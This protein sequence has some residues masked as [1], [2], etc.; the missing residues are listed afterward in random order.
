MPSEYPVSKQVRLL[1]TSMPAEPFAGMAWS[2]GLCAA[3]LDPTLWHESLHTYARATHL[4]VALSDTRGQL[5]GECLNPQPTWHCLQA[6]AA[7]GV[8]C[9]V[10][11]HVISTINTNSAHTPWWPGRGGAV[12]RKRADIP[13]LPLFRVRLDAVGSRVWAENGGVFPRT[14]A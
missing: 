12:Q 9:R 7:A 8:A 1:D 13:N 4:A 3:L 14:A 11:T 5:I 2:S 6:A 10:I